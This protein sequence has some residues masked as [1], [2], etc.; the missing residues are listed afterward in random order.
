MAQGAPTADG[1]QQQVRH[2][3]VVEAGRFVVGVHACACLWY[4][5][6]MPPSYLDHL[7]PLL[8]CS[9]AAQ[10]ILLGCPQELAH[11]AHEAM[12]LADL[13][14]VGPGCWQVGWVGDGVGGW[15]EVVGGS[16]WRVACCL[17]GCGQAAVSGGC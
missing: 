17:C 2:R 15:E 1:E 5:S 9:H 11:L 3:G 16:R 7:S 12:L 6:C 13:R 8:A 14:G 4:Q 10:P